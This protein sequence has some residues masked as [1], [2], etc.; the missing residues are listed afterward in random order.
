MPPDFPTIAFQSALAL[1]AILFA[2]YG[3]FF[4]AII[5]QY[6]KVN[7]DDPEKRAVPRSIR[8]LRS[9]CRLITYLVTLNSLIAIYGLV[10]VNMTSFSFEGVMLSVL[11][12]STVIVI[13]FICWQWSFIYMPN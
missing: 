3:I 5:Q 13:A 6:D 1:V 11:L 10:R 2:A 9:V 8:P 4:T 7:F 12:V